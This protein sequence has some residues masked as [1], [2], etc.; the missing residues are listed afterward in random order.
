[1]LDEGRPMLYEPSEALS[2]HGA[3]FAETVCRPVQIPLQEGCSLP[4][5]WMCEWNLG[6]DPVQPERL[7]W[8]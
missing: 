1:M 2:P 4:V 5:E 6:L 8:Q 7:E 3:I